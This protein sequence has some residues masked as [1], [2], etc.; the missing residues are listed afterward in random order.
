ML[1]YLAAVSLTLALVG[2]SGSS[3]TSGSGS[4]SGGTTTFSA[5]VSVPG[6]L[7]G[8]QGVSQN[9]QS[10]GLKNKSQSLPSGTGV[11]YYLPIYNTGTSVLS[12]ASASVS[13]SGVWNIDSSACSAVATNESCVLAV[14]FNADQVTTAAQLSSLVNLTYSNGTSSSIPLTGSVVA[15]GG[16]NVQMPATIVPNESGFAYGVITL[17]NGESNPQQLTAST[18]IPTS[19]TGVSWT[20][21]PNCDGSGSNI[22]QAL[23]AC[24]VAYIYQINLADAATSPQTINVSVPITDTISKVT[25]IAQLSSSVAP[26]LSS[27]PASYLVYNGGTVVVSPAT[28]NTGSFVLQNAGNGTLVNIGFSNLAGLSQ[29]NNCIN[30]APNGTCTVSLN[31]TLSG[32]SIVVTANNQS[33]TVPVIGEALA[34]SPSSYSYGTNTAGT[35]LTTTITISNLGS[36]LFENLT[37]VL[38]GNPAFSKSSSSNCT[39]SLAAFATTSLIFVLPSITKGCSQRTI[40]S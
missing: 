30:I 26:P 11:A 34:V 15:T 3:G 32:N 10:L 29:T 17:F 7:F 40:S 31:G 25:T 33:I 35:V 24:S 27:T 39:S 18:I 2:C 28:N 20:F 16:L 36:T 14:G 13:N 8:A 1:G 22:V 23:H 9:S 6:T 38:S 21:T 19:Q 5:G 37:S 4:E 12:I